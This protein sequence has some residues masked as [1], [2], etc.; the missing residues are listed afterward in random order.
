ML[1]KIDLIRDSLGMLAPSMLLN[2]SMRD[3]RWGLTSTSPA[4]GNWAYTW[5]ALDGA[6]AELQAS[7]YKIEGRTPDGSYRITHIATAAALNREHADDCDKWADAKPCYVRYGDLPHNGRSINHADGSAEA[8]VS[9]YRGQV[10]PTGEARAI[11]SSNDELG[12][13]LGIRSRKLYIV[14]GDLI[15][16]GSDGEP[17]LTNCRIVKEVEA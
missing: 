7:G 3:D 16:T 11:I 12:S 6:L 17:V 14:E 2:K 1:P 15:G 5:E 8:G 10:L 9:V 4:I 13:L